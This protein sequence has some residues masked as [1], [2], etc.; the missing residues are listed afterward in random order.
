M[1]IPLLTAIHVTIVVLWIGGVSFVTIVIF[2]M[3]VQMDDSLE[4]ILMFQR[5]ENV[6]AKQARYYAWTAGVTGFILLYMKGLHTML[7]TRYTVGVSAMLVAWLFYTFV[8]TFEKRIFRIVFRDPQKYDSAKVFRLLARF[9]W[10]ILGVSLAA[11][12]F[13]VW[14]GHG[15]RL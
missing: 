10:I 9:H 4:K 11:I 13:G 2:P 8:L 14:A 12:F 7:F 3:L 15:G 1:L 6:F 5:I